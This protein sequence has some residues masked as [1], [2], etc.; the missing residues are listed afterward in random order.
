MTVSTEVNHNEY[1]GNGV[2]TSFPYT[3]RIFH[4]TDLVVVTASTSGILHTLVLNTDYTVTGA[5]SYT[6]G[7]VVL[8]SPLANGW[9]IAIDRELQVVQETDLR[10]QGKFFAETHEKV[11][12]YLTMLIQQA[13]SKI[14]FLDG[15]AVKVPERGVWVAP[16]I[17]ERRNKLFAWGDSGA[18][19][20]VLPESGSA[21]DVL[22]ELAK[23]TGAGNIG[24]S[25][26]GT[27][28]SEITELSFKTGAV[29]TPEMYGDTSTPGA[30]TAA[31]NAAAND[32]R[33]TG[34][35]LVA[36]ANSYL[37]SGDVNMRSVWCDFSG[38]TITVDT[39]KLFT[40]GGRAG[41]GINPE[42]VFGIIKQPQSWTL[43]PANYPNVTVRCMGAKGQTIRIS[44]VDRIQ[45]YQSTNP[46]TFPDD[47]SQAYS[48]FFIDLAV[49]LGV[50]TDPAYDGGPS[51]DGPAS[52]NQWFN[53]NQFFLGR[54]I[55]FYM[56][57]SYRHNNNRIFGGCFETV[58][59]Y[60][61]IQIG[62]KNHFMDLRCEGATSIVFGPNT[63]GN[64]VDVNWFSSEAQIYQQPP[65]G[66]TV[67]DNG[68]LNIIKDSRISPT[69]SD[70][71]FLV[72][73]NDVVYNGQSSNYNFRL[74]TN[75]AIRSIPRTT[76]RV[77]AESGFAES[78][79]G[80]YFFAKAESIAG[81]TSSYI[82]R[83]YLY[84]KNKTIIPGDLS[85][86]ETSV[87]TSVFSDRVEGRVTDLQPHH[88][89]GILNANVKYVRMQ[90]L[91][92]GSASED[93]ASL[94]QVNRVARAQGRDRRTELPDSL[95]GISSFVTSA[96]TQFVGQVGTLIGGTANDY[97]CV[98]SLVTTLALSASTG[99]TVLTLTTYTA[100]GLGSIVVNDLI[101]ID[102]TDG[103]THWT[104][105]SAIGGGT[106][107]LSLA[108]PVAAFVNNLVY[109]ARLAAR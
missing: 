82:L 91:T 103:S 92:S 88:R 46:A 107:T 68:T 74:A 25:N 69:N 78:G 56:R 30:T 1:T 66:G 22:I 83:I 109:V 101:G 16:V 54:V 5:G 70:C 47:A 31:F 67:I 81:S 41:T 87:F 10:N 61:N 53:E 89:F 42:Q 8:S 63:L 108:L 43:V 65:A 7:S 64:I 52:A 36:G 17:A 102:T 6:G 104:T 28:Q 37:I 86:L 51:V 95:N 35:K 18:P 21:A 97:R 11:F 9:G 100:T 99:A 14:G 12:D 84:D 29:V 44:Q 75:R 2:T 48:K 39:G 19:I 57:G 79:K 77:I 90:L 23:P 3:F 50:D 76:A 26:G 85:N 96:P 24:V 27:V 13:I 40:I 15:K 34:A 55:S 33:I 45:F 98:F 59:G 49:V 80:D 32:C 38:S 58:N 105:V 60:L 4:A 72:T 20:A 62:N 94:V 93:N 73:N 71:V 106:L